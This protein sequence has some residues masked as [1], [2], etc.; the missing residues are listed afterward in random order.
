MVS[1][2]GGKG[3]TMVQTVL[4]AVAAAEMGVT[5]AH[6]HVFF[7]LRTYFTR[8]EDDPEGVAAEAELTPE[9]LWWIRMHPMNSRVNLVQEDA[10]VAVS[11]VEMFG[12]AGGGTLVDVTTE[13]QWRGRRA[14]MTRGVNLGREEGGGAVGEGERLGGAGGGPLVDVTTV[15]LSP[16]PE[17]LVEV[18]ERTGVKIVA[19]T[20]FYIAGS[21]P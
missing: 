16:K 15:G 6:E 5:L 11:E 20:G 17:A 21:Y 14:R 13:R 8:A 2:T 18:S 1:E 4:G 7:D 3:S 10:E 9:R 12:G 19:G